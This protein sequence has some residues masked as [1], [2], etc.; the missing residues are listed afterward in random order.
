MRHRSAPFAPHPTCA[1]ADQSANTAT[2][3]TIRGLI[4]SGTNY[5]INNNFGG[6]G[7]TSIKFSTASDRE[8]AAATGNSGS[9]WV[10][11]AVTINHLR[12]S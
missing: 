5:A 3:E 12:A 10:D 1:V 7:K 4:V 8:A 2:A 6:A 9:R 11:S